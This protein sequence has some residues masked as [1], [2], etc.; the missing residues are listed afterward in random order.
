MTT[1]EILSG[2]IAGDFMLEYS[3]RI[4]KLQKIVHKRNV[5]ETAKFAWI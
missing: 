3:I 5:L 1:Q 2:S 4:P